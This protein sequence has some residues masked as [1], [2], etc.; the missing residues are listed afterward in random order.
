MK[1]D[2]GQE[3]SELGWKRIW[4]DISPVVIASYASYCSVTMR[5][6]HGLVSRTLCSRPWTN[7][8]MGFW[9]LGWGSGSYDGMNTRVY[10]QGNCCGRM[11]DSRSRKEQYGL[12][13]KYG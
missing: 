4:Y 10:H 11:S 5:G 8:A 6:R 9:I 3:L 2:S 1:K 12:R 7:S 13:R